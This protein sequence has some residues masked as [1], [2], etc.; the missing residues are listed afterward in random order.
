M[1][2]DLLAGKLVQQDFS[3][4]IELGG[5]NERI[6]ARVEKRDEQRRVVAAVGKSRVWI[7]TQKQDTDVDRQPRDGVERTDENHGLNDA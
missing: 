7:Q 3:D 5:V 1:F 6:G 2:G 4:G